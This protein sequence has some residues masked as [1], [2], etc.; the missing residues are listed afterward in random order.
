MT[1]QLIPGDTI[2]IIRC[3]HCGFISE[4]ATTASETPLVAGA[5]VQE[6]R[7]KCWKGGEDRRVR[8]SDILRA[9]VFDE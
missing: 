4:V 3:K 1:N 8:E 7:H 5:P 2:L 6:L 9:S